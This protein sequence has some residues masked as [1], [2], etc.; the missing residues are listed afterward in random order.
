MR[1]YTPI[2]ARRM[3][4]L[5]SQGTYLFN[6]SLRENLLLASPWATSGEIE[7]ACTQAELHDFVASL[8]N[9]Y[10]TLVGERGVQF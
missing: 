9:G 10:E 2:D 8:P 3:F 7:T 1:A 4:S 5:V 6:A